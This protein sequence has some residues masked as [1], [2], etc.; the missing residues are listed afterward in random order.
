MASAVESGAAAESPSS[1]GRASGTADDADARDRIA[2]IVI[3][4][5]ARRARIPATDDHVRTLRTPDA[6]VPVS[7]DP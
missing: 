1:G 5:T 2:A 4:M 7:I 3:N 6:A